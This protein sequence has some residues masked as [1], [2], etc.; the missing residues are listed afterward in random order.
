MTG[1]LTSGDINTV[2][3]TGIQMTLKLASFSIGGTGNGADPGD[4]VWVEISPNGGTNWWKT[5]RIQGPAANN[6]YWSYINASAV[7]DGNASPTNYQPAGGG[8]RTA[9]GYG[10]ITITGLPASSNLRVR[11]S[12]K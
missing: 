9:D 10:T 12:F 11:I 4:S 1:T 8:S 3:Y 6:A 2:G 7:Y 5:V